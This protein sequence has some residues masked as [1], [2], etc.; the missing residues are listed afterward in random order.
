[1][2]IMIT[3]T[4]PTTIENMLIIRRTKPPKLSDSDSAQSFTVIDLLTVPVSVP[5]IPR[6][7]LSPIV[8]LDGVGV[9]C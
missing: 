3:E 6:Q 8:E 7:M 2:I 4:E 5:I 9:C 1:M